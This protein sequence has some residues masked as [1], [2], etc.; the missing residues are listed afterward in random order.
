MNFE[1]DKIS[2]REAFGNALLRMA[3]KNDRIVAIAADTTK[4]M[5]FAQMEKKFPNRVVNLGIGEQN[6]AL[7]GAGAAACG[8]KAFIATYAPF[9]AMR[10]LEQVRTFICYPDLDVKIISGLA[11]LS[12]GSEGVTHQ[13]LEDVSIMRVIPGLVV[14]VPADAASTEIITEKITEHQGPVYLRIGRNLNDHTFGPDY[15]FE[16]GK[17]NILKPNGRDAAVIV[18]GA[19]TK[20][21]LAA[22]D[23]L[24][25][26]GY[27]VQVVEMPCVKPLDEEAV[28]TAARDTGLVIT[29]EEN[30]ILGGLGGAVAEVLSDK[31]PTRVKRIG[32]KDQYTESADHDDLLD[33]YG[34]LPAD[35]AAEMEA[36]IKAKK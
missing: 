7:A 21:A 13:G 24:A 11:G 1:K 9:A 3:E 16:I 30:N 33:A 36:A 14:V 2:T 28:L 5:G 32:I 19:V 12:A 31:L 8:G 35:L 22:V 15:R 6:M 29:V 17:A 4:S 20:R 18:N 23:L 34:F 27:A 25:G 10:I 26:K